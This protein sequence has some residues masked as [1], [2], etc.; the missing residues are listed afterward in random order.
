[1]RVRRFLF[2]Y[3]SVALLGLGSCGRPKEADYDSLVYES[4]GALAFFKDPQTGKGFTGIARSR[5]K[6]GMVTAEFAMKDGLFHG[7]VKEWY[8]NGQVKSET[9]FK[10]GERDGRNTEWREDGSVYNERIYSRDKIVEEKKGKGA[11]G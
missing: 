1:M 3:L 2:F 9:E 11:A 7:M 4:R 6:K 10:N 5:D 8:A